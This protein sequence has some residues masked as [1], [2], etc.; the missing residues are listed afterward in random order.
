MFTIM[1]PFCFPNTFLLTLEGKKLFFFNPIL[2]FPGG[3]RGKEPA[4]Q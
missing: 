2:D 3:A 4:C 1:T